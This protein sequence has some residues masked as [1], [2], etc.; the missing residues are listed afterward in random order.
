MSTKKNINMRKKIQTNKGSMED[1]WILIGFLVL[2]FILWLYFAPKNQSS[3]EDPYI[4]I[5]TETGGADFE[6]Y[7]KN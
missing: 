7:N 5:P 4:K 1:L 2:L 3:R 6:T